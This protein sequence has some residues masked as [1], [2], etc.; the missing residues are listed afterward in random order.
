MLKNMFIVLVVMLVIMLQM[1]CLSV[2]TKKHNITDKS[3][4]YKE[5]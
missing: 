1:G 3:L 4:K 5:K 2:V